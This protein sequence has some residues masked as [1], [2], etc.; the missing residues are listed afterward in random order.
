MT[1]L[2]SWKW[3]KD[4]VEIDLSPEE[5]AEKLTMAGIPVATVTKLDAGIEKV[6]TGKLVEVGRHPGADKLSICGVDVGTEILQIVTGADNIRQGDIVPVA[7][8]GAKLPSGLEITES[9][10]RG[11]A[12]N[13]MLCSASELNMELKNLAPEQRTGIYILPS[14]TPLGLDAIKVLGLDDV[15]LEFELTANRADCFSVIGIAREVSALTGKQIR[16]P[17]LS[18]QEKGEN[19]HKF[20]SVQ[21]EAPELCTRFAA[22]VIRNV[23][24]GPSP[25]WMQQRLRAAGMRPISN[26]VDITN[27]VLLEMGQPLHAYD[28]NLIG[29]QTLIARNARK[30]EK[31]TTLDGNKREL[32]EGMLVIADA[33]QPAGVAGVMGGL[34]TEVTAN[35]KAIILESAVFDN[36]SIR[37][38]AKAL[39]LRTEASHRY[40]KGVDING[41]I[42]AIDRAAKLMEELGAGEVCK[43]VI[44]QYVNITFPTQI[45]LDPQRVN[46][47]L[48]TRI[49]TKEMVDILERLEFTVE[50]REILKV[51]V[52]TWRHDVNREADLFEEI[53]RIFG[54][55]N[56]PDTLP[57]GHAMQGGEGYGEEIQTIIRESLVASGLYETVTFSFSHPRILDALR[58]AADSSLR[59][60]IPLLNPIT[61]DF[62]IL[63]TT[64]LG[65]TLEVIAYNINRKVDDV[66]VFE[67]GTVFLPKDLPLTELPIEN[68]MLVGAITGKRYP[69]AWNQGRD[70][71]DFYDLKGTVETLLQDLG[72]ANYRFAPSEHPSLHPG[73]TA[74]IFAGDTEIGVLGE[75]HPLVQEAFGL[76]KQVYLF[77]LSV[78]SLIAAA[79]LIPQ[80]QALPKYP[81]ITRDLALLV[82]NA[83]PATR[84]ISTIQKAGGSLLKEVTIFDVYTGEQVPTGQKSIAFALVY[85]AQDRTLTDKEIEEVQKSILGE[86][87]SSLKAQIRM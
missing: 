53:G 5:L 38:T 50:G 69:T 37:R 84:I 15:V 63:R 68:Q 79:A 81:A 62:P 40:E 18:L 1:M 9:K 22:R 16:M 4:Y 31:L 29:K 78:D 72:I 76:S 86:L 17:L 70:I 61:E 57:K 65:N 8:I 41:V 77:E 47:F 27:Y 73:K 58:M 3:L 19:V 33:V 64:L 56:I 52:P 45:S 75:V 60:A 83:I 26:I 44:D 82:D 80:Y 35:T 71:V 12:S 51:T 32:S 11:V 20:A 87:S 46:R 66:K 25:E 2:I 42:R 10:L 49:A 85:Q 39:G 34:A 14:D 28:Y 54:Y 36:V 30:G 59:K 24:V 13:G 23:K 43:G 55:N 21:I 67:M 48:G 6:V 7:L 74:A